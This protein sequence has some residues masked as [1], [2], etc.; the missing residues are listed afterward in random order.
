MLSEDEVIF[1]A[2]F[3]ESLLHFEC[4]PPIKNKSHCSNLSDAKGYLNYTNALKY[5][6]GDALNFLLTSCMYKSIENDWKTVISKRTEYFDIV[7]NKEMKAR[8]AQKF[9]QYSKAKP[10]VIF[11]YI[12]DFYGD[13]VENIQTVINS[14]RGTLI[15]LDFWASWC[16]PC[17]EESSYFN[18]LKISFNNDD[19]KFIN[20]SS[21]KNVQQWKLAVIADNFDKK[22][23]YRVLNE[24]DPF[25][26]NN[27]V[28]FFPRYILIG[29]DGN[30]IS[31]DA[32]RPSDPELKKLIEEN[33]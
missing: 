31:A 33:L 18:K 9:T 21:D 23:N 32:P 26:I 1:N 27:S 6:K 13:R 4:D 5:F 7:T 25:L 30:I 22:N 12:E 15:L 2:S 29:K 3:L 11:K 16:A 28:T 14:N 8:I 10:I 24:I 20:I 17:R 19:I